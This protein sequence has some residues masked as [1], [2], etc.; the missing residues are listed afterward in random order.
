MQ[1]CL[2]H[3]VPVWFLFIFFLLHSQEYSRLEARQK[4]GHI[5]MW[6]VGQLR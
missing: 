2:G 6:Y 4:L 1:V 5:N 3:I